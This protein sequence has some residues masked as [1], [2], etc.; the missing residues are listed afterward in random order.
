MKTSPLSDRPEYSACI[1]DLDGTI[2]NTLPTVLHYCNR[3]LDH[4]GFSH[5]SADVCQ[6]LCRL[7]I[8]VFYHELLRL[9]GCPEMEVDKLAPEARDFDIESY[10]ADPGRMSKAY[11]GITE[12]LL[13]L[14]AKGILLGVLTN[15]PH[16][17]AQ[18]LIA[19]LFPGLFDNVKGQTTHSISKPDPRCLLDYIAA[20]GLDTGNCLYVG[21][22]DVDMKTAKAAKVD[23]A[24]VSW[25]FQSK[26]HLLEY[27]PDYL[28]EA[29]KDLLKL[30]NDEF[31]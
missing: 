22:S 17:I 2:I 31:I 9:G 25:G 3:T 26:E 4:F 16:I 6:T 28:C 13:A 21:D 18:V 10:A 24:A 8:G 14:R 20:L 5:I 12:L 7:P 1:F 23:V 19:D 29:P 27:A 11:D 15:K 30:F